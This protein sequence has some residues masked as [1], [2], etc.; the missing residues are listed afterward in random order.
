LEVKSSQFCFSLPK[1]A[2]GFT[3]RDE[4]ALLD[5]C[6]T[7]NRIELARESLYLMVLHFS[8]KVIRD[9]YGRPSFS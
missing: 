8:K 5:R 6:E 4:L 1:E 9:L 3:L 2:A 7:Q